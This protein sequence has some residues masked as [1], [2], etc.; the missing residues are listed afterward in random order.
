MGTPTVNIGQ[1]RGRPVFVFRFP[2]SR[3]VCRRRIEH[4]DDPKAVEA[5]RIAVMAEAMAGKKVKP[6]KATKLLPLAG[7]GSMLDAYVEFIINNGTDPKHPSQLK[8]HS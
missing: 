1:V 6:T 4:P 8:M 3:T 5:Q 2:G 7:E